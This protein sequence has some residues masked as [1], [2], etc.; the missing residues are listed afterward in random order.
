MV[1]S[2]PQPWFQE[3]VF[4]ILGWDY[5]GLYLYLK[6][7]Y[8]YNIRMQFPVVLIVYTLRTI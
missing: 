7:I 4:L 2:R 1:S 8:I 5:D 3:G 6:F